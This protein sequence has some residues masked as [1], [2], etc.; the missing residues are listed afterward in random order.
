MPTEND[1]QSPSLGETRR[2]PG[3]PRVSETDRRAAFIAAAREL[4]VEGGYAALTTN[5]VAA[6]AK[7]SKR[8]LYEAFESIDA[9]FAAVVAEHS[10]EM[11]REP[12]DDDALPLEEA[13]AF[14]FNLDIDE[15]S[16]RY[17]A[18]F[19]RAAM[20]DQERFPQS[21]AAI[22]EHGIDP[23]RRRLAG[24]LEQQIEAGRIVDENPDRLARL[25]MDL[26]FASSRFQPGSTEDWPEREMRAEHI[27]WCVRTAL[28]G[29]QAQ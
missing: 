25:L 4:F 1:C 22:V 23:A 10:V 15:A 21:H 19:L 18:A 17:R 8:S 24:W 27:R 11:L 2:T 16:D 6:H 5:A 26:I 28:R 20:L 14:I 12:P 9:L 7:A 29:L 13:I 3:R